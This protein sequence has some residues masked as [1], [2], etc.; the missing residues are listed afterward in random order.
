MKGKKKKWL[1]AGGVAVALCL[2][3]VVGGQLRG[4]T[5][6][7]AIATMK[8]SK[9]D[10]EKSITLKA[11]LEGMDKA[12]VV[13]SLHCEVVEL[14]VEEGDP[15]A[16][17]QLLAVLDDKDLLLA[18]EKAR[19][20][21][22]LTR[23][24][25]QEG[26]KESQRQYA[27]IKEGL[28]AAQKQYERSQALYEAGSLSLQELETAASSLK[29]L[30]NQA[31]AFSVSKDNV[32]LSP[33]QNKQLNILEKALAEAEDKLAQAQVKSPIDGIVTRVNV[34]LGRFADETENKS[35]MF[36]IEDL[37]KLQ[38]KVQ[39]SEY[40][41][42]EVA[43]GQEATIS[44]DILGGKAVTGQVSR[45]SPTGESKS[46]GTERIIPTII[47]IKEESDQLIAGI[48]AKAVIHLAKS[49]NT[50]ILPLEA[51]VE[52]ENAEGGE[53]WQVYRVTAAG[54]LELIDVTLGVENDLQAE[55][56]SDRLAE[57]DTIV[58]IITPDL[59]EGMQVPAP[60][61]AA[62][63]AETEASHE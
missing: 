59:H 21:L 7:P 55:I 25:Y 18:V 28:A 44:A 29:D 3:L 24:Q 54:I 53:A 35:P 39:I 60:E 13:S 38:M 12:E 34:R 58:T 32:V 40:D 33:S 31:A 63:E 49:E 26:L 51:L 14:K 43:V 16:K 11:P 1:I 41:I 15:V 4:G 47:D 56:F 50:F 27:K 20:Q 57:G 46:G 37:S 36:V 5:A 2:I 17:D 19:D 30:E 8:L 45:I 10:I 23:F 9:G 48:N 52:A 61:G 42:G 62:A 6:L 22:E